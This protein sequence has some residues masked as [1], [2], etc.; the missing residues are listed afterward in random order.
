MKFLHFIFKCKLYN[1]NYLYLEYEVF[2][3][4]NIDWHILINEYLFIYLNDHQLAKRSW[5]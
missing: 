2:D 4:Q 5:M 1:L 3:K